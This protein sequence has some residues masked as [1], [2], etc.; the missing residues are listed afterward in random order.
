M[1]K[2][3]IRDIGLLG[4]CIALGLALRLWKLDASLWYDEV[5]TLVDYVRLTPLEALTTYTSMNNHVFFTLQAQL[6]VA[7]LGENPW[8]LRLPAVV[9]GVATIPALFLLV[10]QIGGGLL[11]AHVSALLLAVNYHHIWFSQNARGYTG[12]IFW[13]LLAT[14]AFLAGARH[15]GRAPWVALSL[16]A[17]AAL[18][19]HLSAAFF[20]LSFALIYAVAAAVPALR[21]SAPGLASATPLLAVPLTAV[22][23][24][25]LYSGIIP[26][27]LATFDD[28]A[29]P[30]LSA[31]GVEAIPEWRSPLWTLIEVLRSLPLPLPLTLVVAPALLVVLLAGLAEVWRLNRVLALLI[32]VSIAVTFA[33]LIASG[34]R[35]WPRFFL[36]DLPFLLL[37]VTAGTLVVGRW[38]GVL[39]RAP[40][41]GARLG[42]AGLVLGVLASALWAA[43]NYSSPKQ[44]FTGAIAVVEANAAPDD[45]RASVGLAST[46]MSKYFRPDWPVLETAAD[47]DRLMAQGKPVWVVYSFA[48]HTRIHRADV[49]ARLESD[50]VEV[51]SLPGTLGVGWMT[52]LRSKEGND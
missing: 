52:V 29:T 4:L 15:G 10:R 43:Q 46:P 33:I 38:I 49:M 22:L 25:V 6:S 12:L 34:M 26:D 47:L 39:M 9:F 5:L 35:I 8:A 13:C 40:A 1:T 41:L 3:S 20:L 21:R 27:M 18:F 32:P 37:M 24:L 31:G 23:V 42:Q 48:A 16:A 7:L 2:I 28:V 30:T 51:A 19:T 50:F 36:A 17:T 11:L 14:M 45:L 44:D